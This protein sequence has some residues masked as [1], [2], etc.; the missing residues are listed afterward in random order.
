MNDFFFY[1]WLPRHVNKSVWRL[2]RSILWPVGSHH[3]NTISLC[4]LRL[5][6]L[7]HAVE[8]GTAPAVWL[9]YEG[10]AKSLRRLPVWAVLPE[11]GERRSH[12]VQLAHW[13]MSG[14]CPAR[15]G[16]EL[17]TS[18][19][20]PFFFIFKTSI[21]G[22]D[23]VHFGFH[24]INWTMPM[25]STPIK[26]RRAVT[27]VGI[28]PSSL[29]CSLRVVLPGIDIGCTLVTSDC[30]K[31]WELNECEWLIRWE[32]WSIGGVRLDTELSG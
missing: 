4:V 10:L 22:W 20:L 29:N 25:T 15:T 27:T 17:P 12:L 21:R 32:G 23:I 28:T 14:P 8:R 6:S 3:Q 1:I 2:I 18:R 26:T 7:I 31:E 24:K 13:P 11:G 16:R 9:C 5:T 30:K 19:G